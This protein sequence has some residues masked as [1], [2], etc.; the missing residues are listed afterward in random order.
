[1]SRRSATAN[2]SLLPTA[3]S[4]KTSPIGT[5]YRGLIQFE[6]HSAAF[7]FELAL[8]ESFGL[9]PGASTTARLSFWADEL[10]PLTS[11]MRFNIFEGTR[12]VGSGQITEPSLN[13]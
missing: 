2:V 1:V 4:G 8:N 13:L 9:A 5:G 11:G 3:E 12:K 6:G 7:G 10:P